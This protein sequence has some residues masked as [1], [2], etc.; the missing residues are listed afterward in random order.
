M[1]KNKTKKL[2]TTTTKNPKFR[3]NTVLVSLSACSSSSVIVS[4]KSGD[5]F[6]NVYLKLQLTCHLLSAICCYRFDLLK[7]S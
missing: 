4:A 7:V 6:V 5:S 3:F 2:K 1:G